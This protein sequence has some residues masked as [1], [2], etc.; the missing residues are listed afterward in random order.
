MMPKGH[1]FICLLLAIIAAPVAQIQAQV[2][3]GFASDTTQGCAPL[4]IRFSDRSTGNPVFWRWE[5]GNGTVSFNQNPST[6]YFTAGTY[7]IRLFVRNAA[8]QEDSIMKTQYITAYAPPS[9][10]F[11]ASDTMGCF[12]LKVQFTDLSTPG[13]GTIISRE[14]DF[15]D[16]F[17]S[18]ETNPLHTYTALG[19]YNVSLRITNSNGCA[20]TLSK[21]QYVKL[22]NGAKA[23]FS[24][25]A[26]NSCRP[27]TIINFTNLSAGTGTLGYAWSFGDGSSSALS[28]PAHSY[29]T[30]GTYT[31]RLIV[32]NNAGCRDT[33]E[34]VNAITIGTVTAGFSIPAQ[35]CAG[36]SFPL[37]NTS[38]PAPSGAL[39]S[40]GDGSF[41]SILN[42]V[43]TF[44]NAG[45]YSIKLVSDFGA[46]KDS[47][48]RAVTVLPKPVS[49]FTAVNNLSCQA[50]L[51]V[52]F[53]SSSVNAVSYRWLFGDGSSSTDQNPSHLY[54]QRGEYDVTL[55][56]T[57]ANGC[58]DS[59][60]KPG[61]VKI[62]P[63]EVTIKNLPQQGCVPLTFS[64]LTSINSVEPVTSYYWDFGDGSSSTDIVPTHIYTKPGIYTLKLFFTTRGGC[65]DSVV[66]KDQVMAGNEPKVNFS[67]TPVKTCAFQPVVFT[68]MTTGNPLTEWFWEFGDGAVSLEQNPAHIY[69]DTGYFTVKLVVSSNGCKTALTLPDYV[70]IR[71]PIAIFTDSSSCIN[72][73]TRKFTDF[74][75]DASSWF[76]SFGDSTS[77]TE[78]N[79]VHTYA[80]PGSYLVTLTVKND[81]CENTARQQVQIIAEKADFTASD[82]V[83]CKGANVTFQ[84]RN[85]NQSNISQQIWFFGDGFNSGGTNNIP[86]QYSTNGRF[87]VQLFIRDVNGCTDT[88]TKTQY[89]RVTGPVADF[90]AAVKNVCINSTVSF[91]DHSSSDTSPIRQWNWKY[92]DGIAETLTQPPFQHTYTTGGTFPVQLKVTDSKGCTDSVIKSGLVFI[93]K[94]VAVF[95]SPDSLSC[96]NRPIRFLNQSAGIS[97]SNT[98]DFGDNSAA[99]TV[100]QP[101]HSYAGEG[102]YTV[103]LTVK[104]QYGCLDSVTRPQYIKIRNPKPAFTVNDSVAT[105]PPLVTTFKNQ[106]LNYI[107]Y[108]WDFGDGTSSTVDNPT[109]FYNSSGTFIAKLVVISP[110]GCK[111][112]T[113]RNIVVRGPQGNLTYNKTTG[114]LPV[115]IQFKATT[116]DRLSFLWDFNDG[117]TVS[118]ADSL[119]SH[120]FTIAGS[121]V[122]KIIL[123]DPQGCKVPV[124]GK[125]TIHV[126]GV[127]ANFSVDK[128]TVCD[129]GKVAFHDASVSNDMI[130]SYRWNLGDGTISTESNPVHFYRNIGTYPVRLTVTTRYGCTDSIAKATDLLVV[131]SPVTG[132]LGDSAACA[133]AAVQFAGLVLKTD[134][135]S[136]KWQWNFG[137][138]QQGNTQDPAPVSY[139]VAGDYRVSLITTNNA[140]CADTTLK[141]ITIH[142]SPAVDAGNNATICKGATY[143]LQGLHA[144]AYLWSPALHLSCVNCANPVATPDLTTVFRLQGQTIFGC[145]GEDSVIIEVK[146]PF[147]LS[148]S[149]GDTLCT[150]NSLTLSATGAELYNWTPSAGLDNPTSSKPKASPSVTT[151]YRI[152]GTDSKNC[153]SDT[154]YVPL[155]VYPYPSIDAGEDKTISVGSSVIV[156]PKISSDVTGIRWQPL[157][158]LSCADCNA[159]VAAPRQTTTYTISV[160]NR[161]ACMAKDEMTVFVVCKEGNL[162]MPNTF[163]PN[164]DGNNDVFYPRGKGIYGVRS[165][166]IFNRWGETVYEKYNFQA[167]DASP[168][169]GW[170]GRYKDKEAGQD[171]YVYIIEVICENST[172]IIYKGNVT[173]IR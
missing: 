8:N 88:L 128:L 126:L 136:L 79:P 84:T 122:P 1:L 113:T 59:L 91:N 89:I 86:H 44:A 167:N 118:S 39:W 36:T 16:G 148:V 71:P 72:P 68:D 159:P 25:T 40:F 143:Q 38:S 5:L 144:D 14:W 93:S 21:S 7:T 157:T 53:T 11:K 160:S 116:K 151:N 70:F 168:N 161:G 12:P 27:P 162:Y 10:N 107:A 24:V 46:C 95:T 97:L 74:S 150:G 57:G 37:T 154:A 164:G 120:T 19:N 104:D 52:A 130:A 103:R 41:S 112:S 146:Q 55:I 87:T 76:W 62:L 73:L 102:A 47:V 26:P 31:V 125:D 13:S 117:F 147:K 2:T 108:E 4:V 111:D 110:G 58:S 64:P 137:N 140:G 90:D 119:I 28:N 109:H 155:V 92:G 51:A 100:A 42:P 152:I 80:K 43:K 56:T 156:T 77:S 22:S 3:A 50:P 20:T 132:I 67:A 98:W 135:A 60:Q 166:K 96:Y 78:Q 18:G 63:A 133:P 142:P 127:T 124:E 32:L 65:K 172:V 35:V 170:N 165:F 17:T 139:T 30:A 114:C 33:L 115:T 83:V 145:K 134:T 173:L 6:T 141:T 153:F 29:I 54:Q 94:P 23:G 123:I 99:S 69:S 15:G 106:S 75:L 61:F 45:T 131:P 169:T 105:C 101:S 138:G 85:I 158:G 82:T 129:S 49:A 149:P 66:Y 171:V 34:K 48:I 81:T 121:Y 9:L 163:S